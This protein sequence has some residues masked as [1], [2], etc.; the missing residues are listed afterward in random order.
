MVSRTRRLVRWVARLVTAILA[1]GLLFLAWNQAHSNFGP[2]Q[3]GRVYR[4]G[5]MP[6]SALRR[7]IRDYTIK[8]VL[9]LRGRNQDDWYRSERAATLDSGATQI[10]IPMS[11]CVWMSRAQLVTLVEMLDTAEYPILIHC[12]WGSERTGLVSAFA[13]L[14]RPGST[15]ADARAQFSIRYLF[16]RVKDG[17]IMA[18][19][20]DQYE[21]WL[22]THGWE[23]DPARFR[24][25]VKDGFRPR[26][27]NREQWPYDPYPLVVITRPAATPT[28]G[29][30]ARSPG[31][32]RR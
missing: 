9:N 6:A 25:W 31:Q 24:Q 27:P 32:V 17:K 21:G 12:Q 11:S 8:T 26:A 20:L 10:D 28:P 18:E 14:L 5:Q 13:E 16:L 3:D 22:R 7:T 4:S 19:H 2:V 23:H 15:L 1:A 30:V 29:T